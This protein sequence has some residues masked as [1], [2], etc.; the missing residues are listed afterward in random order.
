MIT[1]HTEKYRQIV[2]VLSIKEKYKMTD[3][4][5]E[6][7]MP[8]L[9]S[10]YYDTFREYHLLYDNWTEFLVEKILPEGSLLTKVKDIHAFTGLPLNQCKE[11]LH[12]IRY[13]PDAET[14]RQSV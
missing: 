3:T 2:Y 6:I 10:V 14:G 7:L 8:N 13:T 11:L 1:D 5:L 4:T 9:R 12:S